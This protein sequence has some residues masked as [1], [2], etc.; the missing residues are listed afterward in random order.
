ML[1]IV[2]LLQSSSNRIRR[3]TLTGYCKV[4][5]DHV[6]A[7]LSFKLVTHR[8]SSCHWSIERKKEKMSSPPPNK[9]RKELFSPSPSTPRSSMGSHSSPSTPYSSMGS[10]TKELQGR[11]NWLHKLGWRSTAWG[12][13]PILQCVS[14]CRQWGQPRNP[15]YVDRRIVDRL[16]AIARKSG[17]LHSSLQQLKETFFHRKVG[18]S[19]HFVPSQVK[20]P[21]KA[22]P[23]H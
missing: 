15:S 17:K 23:A 21:E 18:L 19:C 9:A 16:Q 4:I 7:L 11:H 1:I 13:K 5:W 8:G 14:K 20:F 6:T 22:N 2:V 12:K 10:T 3:Q